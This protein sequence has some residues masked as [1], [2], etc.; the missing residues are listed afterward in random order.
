M[1]PTPGDLAL[2]EGQP[3]VVAGVAG[4]DRQR[5]RG[6][7]RD[8]DVAAVRGHRDVA[9]AEESADAELALAVE[10]EEGDRAGRPVLRWKTASVLSPSVSD[11]LTT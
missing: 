9:G 8:V 11:W 6:P 1:P 4:E 2:L 10:L 7:A 5:A 3:S